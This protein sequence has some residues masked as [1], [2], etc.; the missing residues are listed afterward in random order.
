MAEIDYG[1]DLRNTRSTAYPWDI[2]GTGREVRGIT[3]LVEALFRRLITPRGRLIGDPDYGFDVRD[4]VNEGLSEITGIASIKAQIEMECMKDQ[5][6]ESVDVT[7]TWIPSTGELLLEIVGE[8][9]LGP[10]SLVLS[11][12][13]ISVTLLSSQ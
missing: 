6:V 2:D 7:P 10:F 1:R 8:S 9:G 11:V 5:Q 12:T 3:L 4:L 13:T